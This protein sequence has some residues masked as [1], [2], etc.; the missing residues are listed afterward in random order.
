[1]RLTAIRWVSSFL[2]L[3]GTVLAGTPAVGAEF[4]V[5]PKG[6]DKA[7]GTAEAPFATPG[8]ARLAVRRWTAVGLKEDVTVTFRGGTYR[9][10]RHLPMLVMDGGTAGHSVTWRAAAGERVVFSG[11]KVLTGGTIWADGLW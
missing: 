8:R 6:D 11:G 1:M 5:S 2:L 7:A 3:L 9:L 10:D 4:F